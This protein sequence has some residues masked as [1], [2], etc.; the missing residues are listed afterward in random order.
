MQ[1]FGLAKSASGLLSLLAASLLVP[2]AF[3]GDWYVDAVHGNNANSGTSPQAAWR[4]I[5]HA[6]TQLPAGSERILVA[7]GTYNAALGEVFPIEPKP[8]HQIIGNAGEVRPIISAESVVNSRLFRY[9]S[10]VN[11]PRFFGPDTRLENLVLRRADWG[12][13]L[14]ALSGD[15]SPTFVDLE[16]SRMTWYGIQVLADD[17][18]SSP[19]IERTRIG[20]T[21]PT[22]SSLCVDCTGLSSPGILLRMRDCQLVDNGGYGLRV[23]GS[24]DARLESCQIDSQ[25]FTGIIAVAGQS[26]SLRL[27]C[28]DTVV[29]NN[30]T[31]FEFL[32]DRGLLSA[33]FARCSIGGSPNGMGAYTTHPSSSLL[34]AFD[35]SLVLTPG[36]LL[37]SFSNSQPAVFRSFLSDASYAGINGC[38]TGDARVRDEVGG[39]LRLRY[40]SPCI[41]AALTN[42]PA[43]ARD[44]EGNLR[45]TDGNLDR[46]GQTDIGAFEFRPLELDAT[47]VPGSSLQL[48]SWGEQGAMTTIY[49]TRKPIGA[50]ITTPFGAF[51]LDP[52]LARVFAVKDT[53]Y[54]APTLLQRTIP[55]GP[56]LVGRTFSF[57][58]LVDSSASPIQKAFTNAVEVTVL[59]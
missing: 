6:V 59:P 1:P 15:V 19:T 41:D 4:T 13:E 39:D 21:V 5:S 33:T 18:T 34:L 40:G 11:A 22:G 16:L 43:G 46:I 37:T 35:S 24:V 10:P 52:N 20:N 17:G 2:S 27:E 50:P 51:L 38:I 23:R 55:G 14:L 31:P 3:A 9:E 47:G 28:V 57:Q 53:G 30:L 54:D 12:I 44:A 56:A 42:A 49:W 45:D 36:P 26:D 48:R 25:V 29:T 7:A 58:A 8:G 32:C